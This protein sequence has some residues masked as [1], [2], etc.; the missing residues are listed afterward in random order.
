MINLIT[1]FVVLP[2]VIHALVAS[3]VSRDVFTFPFFKFK[4]KLLWILVAW[5]IPFYG[6]S[7]VNRKLKYRPPSG[8]ASGGD[9]YNGGG[10]GGDG[11][12]D[13]GC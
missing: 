12:G 7:I 10:G 2:I 4:Q 9:P 13:G 6:S 8:Y 5:L 11:G 1:V 3:L